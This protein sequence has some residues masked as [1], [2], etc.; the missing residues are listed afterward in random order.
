MSDVSQV[1]SLVSP[2]PQDQHEGV[3]ISV[4][5]DQPPQIQVD[6]SISKSSPILAMAA[7]TPCRFFL[8]ICSGVSRPLS[9][10][11]LSRGKPVLSFDI[12]LDESM[13]LLTDAAFDKLPTVQPARHAVITAD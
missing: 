1:S 7:Q 13:D 6:R 9:M 11:V 12:L 5:Q 3:A 8:D 10:A 2:Q 4:P